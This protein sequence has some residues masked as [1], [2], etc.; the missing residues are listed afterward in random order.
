MFGLALVD[1]EK[2][3]IFLFFTFLDKFENTSGDQ[4]LNS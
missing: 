1:F 2:Y 3:V 4:K